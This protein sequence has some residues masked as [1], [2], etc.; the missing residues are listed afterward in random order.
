MAQIVR[1]DAPMMD[2]SAGGLARSFRIGQEFGS[3][4]DRVAEL[5]GSSAEV[6]QDV[7]GPFCESGGCPRQ[8]TSGGN[9]AF[10]VDEPLSGVAVQCMGAHLHDAKQTPRDVCRV[11]TRD[12]LAGAVDGEGRLPQA[13]DQ[14]VP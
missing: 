2:R 10:L 13:G 4:G 5:A 3:R 1:F 7:L 11:L 9:C 14:S 12:R 8:P 6:G